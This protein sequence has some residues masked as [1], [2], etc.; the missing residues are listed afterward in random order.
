[1]PESHQAA[2]D[3]PHSV[4]REQALEAL[5]ADPPQCGLDGCDETLAYHHAGEAEAFFVCPFAEKMRAHG[6]LDTTD[7]G[8]FQGFPLDR[9][10]GQ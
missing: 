8:R 7:A 1:M 4:R 5:R 2:V 9:E 3:P 10:R 6:C